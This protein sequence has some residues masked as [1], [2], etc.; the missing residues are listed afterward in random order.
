MGDFNEF[1]KEQL[2]NPKIRREYYRLNPYYRL[3]DLLV[4][5]RKLRG[6]TQQ[7]LAQ[8]SNTTQAVVSRLENVSVHCSLETV[9]RLAEAMDAV[10]ELKLVPVEELQAELE[11]EQTGSGCSEG[12]GTMGEQGAV[13]FG[14]SE[15]SAQPSIQ[16]YQAPATA[17][18][19]TIG[20]A[21]K[22]GRKI[23]HP[24]IA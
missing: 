19:V 22:Q 20:A 12:G 13:F 23:K 5:L 18:G 2:K 6:I 16:W 15:K 14:K 24:E 7:E 4:L 11:A 17:F 9:V 8:K 1:L 3:S 10:V 21:P